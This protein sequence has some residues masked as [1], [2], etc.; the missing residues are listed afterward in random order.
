[1]TGMIPNRVL[2]LSS[3]VWLQR[4]GECKRGDGSSQHFWGNENPE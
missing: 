1:M 3:E 2:E 4:K